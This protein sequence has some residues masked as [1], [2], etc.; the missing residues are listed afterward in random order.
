M[1]GKVR[2]MKKLR[3]LS[4]RTLAVIL[5]VLMVVYLLLPFLILY[6]CSL[7]KPMQI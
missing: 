2:T 4:F 1:K 7:A 3:K 6:L 5:S